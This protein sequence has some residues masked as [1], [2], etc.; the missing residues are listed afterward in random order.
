MTMSI[1]QLQTLYKLVE[2]WELDMIERSG[3]SRFPPRILEQ[4]VFYTDMSEDELS[5]G[6]YGS[7]HIIKLHVRKDYIVRYK[8]SHKEHD[9]LCV[10]AE[11]IEDLN[12]NIIGLIE[13][14]R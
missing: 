7:Q 9:E 6:N 10:P 1:Y 14:A 5:A 13:L 3:W 4:P 11:S 2:G 8:I 12:N